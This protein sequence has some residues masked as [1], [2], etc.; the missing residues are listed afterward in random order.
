MKRKSSDSNI[1]RMPITARRPKLSPPKCLTKAEASLF[2]EL[3]EEAPYLANYRDTTILYVQ[4]L[5]RAQ[6]LCRSGSVQESDKA[7]RLTMALARSLRLTPQ[8]V[9]RRTLERQR[10]KQ[11]LHADDAHKHLRDFRVDDDED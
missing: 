2:T 4:S 8:S 1:I 5:T 11:A 9:D 10:A 3:L 6:K 7:I